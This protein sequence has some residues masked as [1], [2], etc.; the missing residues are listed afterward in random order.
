MINRDYHIHTNLCDGKDTP[1][2]MVLAA[3]NKGFETLGFSG[4]SPLGSEYWCM[5]SENFE[6][7][8]KEINSLKEKYKDKIEILCGI[9]QDYYSE[10]STEGF[11][12]VIG[13]VHGIKVSDE[14]IYMDDTA[15][16]LQKG[17][18]K[19]FGGDAL[20]LAERYFE[21]VA[22]IKNK[23]GA[24]IVGHFDLLLKFEE[25]NPLFDTSNPRYIAAA[26]RA[27][28]TLSAENVLFEINTGAMSR[29]Y[30]SV[31]YPEKQMLEYIRKKGCDI[32]LTSDC[33][34]KDSLGFAFC[35]A[36]KLAKEC[37]FERIAYLTK[38]GIKY[39]DI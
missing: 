18:N 39:M 31:P 17:I 26:K 30:K 27:I 20:L 13:S 2:D 29:G 28:D 9:E 10:T 16:A 5:S 22:D 25:R 23:T 3:I 37:S 1:E 34:Q 38:N 15:N 36:L 7:Y 12:Y 24:T 19:H 14:M 4:H 33:H 32:I 6:V 11:D 8:K 21:L 35:D